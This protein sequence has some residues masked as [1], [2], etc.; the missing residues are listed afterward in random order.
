MRPWVLKKGSKQN[1]VF[2]GGSQLCN[3]T[4]FLLFVVHI[5]IM[6]APK[7]PIGIDHCTGC[8]TNTDT[9]RAFKGLHTRD[10]ARGRVRDGNRTSSN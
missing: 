5:Y 1:N 4:L 7:G 10:T 3:R 9:I 2:S 8:C 6:V